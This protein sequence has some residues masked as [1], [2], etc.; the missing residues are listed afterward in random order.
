MIQKSVLTEDDPVELLEGW[1]V[2]KMPRTP[3]HDAAITL[4]ESAIRSQ[5]PSGWHVRV[6]CAITTSDSEPEPDLA[7]VAGD[8]RSYLHRHP[9]PSD[10]GLLVESSESSLDTDRVEKGRI[11]ARAKIPAYWV[12]NLVDRRVEAYSDP[13]P[14]AAPPAYRRRQTF[15]S[16]QTIPLLLS[17]QTVGLIRVDDILP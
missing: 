12:V 11:Y 8:P 5:L 2:Q 3:G 1:I 10:I 14:Q 15:G 6:Q 13:D 7:V 16:G 9:S 17:A 4:T